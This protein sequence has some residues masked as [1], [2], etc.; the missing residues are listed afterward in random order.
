MKATCKGFIATAGAI[1]LLSL[2]PM[3]SASAQQTA[4]EAHGIV[5]ANMD[6]SIVP[7]DDFYSFVNGAWIKRTEI[8]PDRA[9][10]G[11]FSALGDLTN[12][13]TAALIEEAA[14]S[15]APGDSSARQ[16]AD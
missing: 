8:P 13:R 11:V 7:G 6:R 15:K 12:K 2:V 1:F 14:K 10:I 16:I 3:I 5:V 9:G 4:S